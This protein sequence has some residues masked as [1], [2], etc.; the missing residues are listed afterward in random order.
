M[1]PKPFS[2]T[3]SYSSVS[4]VWETRL[5]MFLAYSPPA[6]WDGFGFDFSVGSAVPENSTWAMMLLGFS[7]LGYTGYRRAQ[8]VGAAIVAA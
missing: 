7:G 3:I 2:T 1:A 8:K 4:W 6:E 5:S